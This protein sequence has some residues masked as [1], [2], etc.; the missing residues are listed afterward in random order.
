MDTVIIVA[1]PFLLTFAAA[2]IVAVIFHRRDAAGKQQ[3]P[4]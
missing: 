3:T 1:A 2:G 4:E